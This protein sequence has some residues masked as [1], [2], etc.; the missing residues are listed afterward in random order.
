MRFVNAGGRAGLLV[1]DMVYDVNELSGDAIPYWPME[2]LVAHWEAIVNLHEVG[3]FTGGTPL[4]QVHLGPPVPRPSSVFAIGVNYRGHAA[5]TG[6]DIRP[7]PA[8]FT[9]FPSSI[10]GPYDDVVLPRGEGTTDWEAELA[11]VMGDTGRNIGAKQALG[12]LRGFMCAQDISERF[13]QMAASRQ[14]SLGKSYDTFCPL[15]PALVTLDE[16]PDP[17]SL[18]ISCRVNGEV[19]QDS[20][21]SDMVVDVP[22]LVELLSSVMTLRPGDVCLTGTP[23]GVGVARRPPVFLKPGDVVETEI[24]GVGVLR[25]R[26]VAE[27]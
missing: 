8:V 21:T 5:E 27:D 23:A 20:S 3:A 18:R 22:H 7:I 6:A 2:A 14:F 11:F 10:N 25:N 19:M 26:C 4:D 16:L 17:L 9:K 1:D 12:A 15:G 24:E 13:V